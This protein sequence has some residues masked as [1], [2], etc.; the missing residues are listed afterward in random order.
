MKP[1]T[2]II[3]ISNKENMNTRWKRKESKMKKKEKCKN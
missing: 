2:N 1:F 3:K